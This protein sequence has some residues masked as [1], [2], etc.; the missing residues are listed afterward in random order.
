MLS[1]ISSAR[2]CTKPRMQSQNTPRKNQQHFF[3][4]NNTVH[5]DWPVHSS[6]MSTIE[7]VKEFFENE[8]SAHNTGT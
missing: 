4:Q 1:F 8:S 3:H 7:H 6:D 2:T 5:A